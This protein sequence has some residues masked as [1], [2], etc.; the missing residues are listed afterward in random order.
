MDFRD[1]II[2]TKLYE[3]REKAEYEFAVQE[4]RLRGGFIYRR[5]ARLVCL[6]SVHRVVDFRD[7]MRAEIV[8]STRGKSS[9]GGRT[10]PNWLAV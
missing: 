9:G 3:W 4:K 8:G 10:E 2:P 7:N 6:E 1:S 5:S